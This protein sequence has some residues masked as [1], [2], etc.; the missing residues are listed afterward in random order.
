[1]KINNEILRP[2]LRREECDTL[3][4]LGCYLWY[5]RVYH[6]RGGPFLT[7][8]PGNVFVG[9]AIATIS[10]PPRSLVFK[11]PPI[12]PKVAIRCLQA[13]ESR[14]CQTLPIFVVSSSQFA[15]E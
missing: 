14:V 10:T 2:S 15:N 11:G 3:G 8:E 13:P 12:Q 5:S 9:D 6:R 1:M 4:I 7:H